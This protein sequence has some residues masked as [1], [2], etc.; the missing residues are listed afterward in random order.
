MKKQLEEFLAYLQNSKKLSINTIKSYSRDIEHLISFLEKNSVNSFS[1]VKGTLLNVYVM[2]LET[3]GRAASTISRN[4]ASIRSIFQYIYKM[5]EIDQNPAD[6]LLAPKIEKKVPDILT[7][8]EVDLLLSQ[9]IE[10]E[11]K[12][13]RDKAMLE[14]LYA[15]GIRVSELINLKESDINLSLSYIKCRDNKKER[16]IPFGHAAKG[17]LTKYMNKSRKVMTKSPEEEMLFVNCLGNAMSRQGFWKIIKI[18]ATKAR[19]NKTITPHMLRHSF[20]CHLVENGA[21]LNSVKE[22]LGHSD[23]ASTQIYAKM[24]NQKLKDVYTKAHP[25]A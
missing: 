17:A 20:A 23:I 22:M 19:I 24:N 13:V 9:P 10:T 18:Y 12:G 5:G 15:T 7:L 3:E 16:V 2:Q 14:L 25:R 1:K 4:I 6:L 21:D 8:S 11:H